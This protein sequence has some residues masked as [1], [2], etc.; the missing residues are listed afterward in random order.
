MGGAPFHG[1]LLKLGIK[2]SQATVGRWM[3]WRP[4]VPSPTYGAFCATICPTLRRL[5]VCSR[6]RDVPTPLYL[7]LCSASIAARSRWSLHEH[8]H[9]LS[10]ARTELTRRARG[11][12]G[13]RGVVPASLIR[14]QSLHG[15]EA[16][17][18]SLASTMKSSPNCSG[19]F[20]ISAMT[21]RTS[22]S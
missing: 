13:S 1:E 3:P 12:W 9:F 15:Q 20:S 2:I 10:L 6:H 22:G 11:G 5:T 4:R 21:V 7:R 8:A 18:T 19:C 17:I 14:I 16:M